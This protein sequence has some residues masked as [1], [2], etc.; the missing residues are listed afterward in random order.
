M[1][2]KR[3]VRVVALAMAAQSS[4][5]ASPGPLR[6]AQPAYENPFDLAAGGA[7]ITRATQDGVVFVNP[8]LAAFG[9]GV[10]RSIYLR[11]AYHATKETG[12]FARDL[13]SG[14]A[15]VDSSFLKKALRTPYHAGVDFSGGFIT[16]KFNLGLFASTRIDIQG[17][18]F[19]SAGLPELTSRS[20]AHG[21][22]AIGLSHV[23][24]DTVA[25]GWSSKPIYVAE[26]AETIGLDDL[27]AAQELQSRLK[28]VLKKGY[29][30]SNDAALTLQKRS[31]FVDIR[32]AGVAYDVG[33]TKFKGGPAPWKMTIGT[34]VGVTLHTRDSAIHC[35]YDIRDV[36]KAYGQHITKRT[37]YGCRAIAARY[38]GIAAGVHQG[39]FTYGALLNLIILRLEA[40][41]YGREMG[42]RVGAN[43]RR[44]YF[45]ALGAELP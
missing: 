45:I 36:S 17:S 33:E 1:H 11:N 4:A 40:G 39:Y 13:Q 25:I 16:S 28:R 3:V 38:F 35:A 29:G 27:Q 10:L 23:F 12:F 44:V 26:A 15:K 8:S 14:N 18:Q 7:S 41:S 20:Y 34:G 2:W 5:W 22:V 42:N 37:H 30:L 6:Q 31:R 24:A 21:G 19:G 9:A 43:P 32:L